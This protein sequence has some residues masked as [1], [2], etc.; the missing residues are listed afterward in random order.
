MTAACAAER[1]RAARRTWRWHL[2][3]H[4]D[5]LPTTPLRPRRLC[6]PSVAVFSADGAT[7]GEKRALPL[8]GAPPLGFVAPRLRNSV[9]GDERM[10]SIGRRTTGPREGPPE[11][12]ERAMTHRNLQQPSE[13]SPTG[14]EPARPR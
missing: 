5:N 10:I 8:R 12:G 3:C 2:S 13:P 11:Q 14:R 6:S 7:P 9:A 1:Y 4:R